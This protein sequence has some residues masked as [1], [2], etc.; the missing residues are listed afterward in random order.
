MVET[1]L[2]RSPDFH[3]CSRENELHRGWSTQ[4]D[5]GM[6]TGARRLQEAKS[7]LTVQP[8]SCLAQSKTHS[9]ARALGPW[10]WRTTAHGHQNTLNFWKRPDFRVAHHKA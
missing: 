2:R 4:A 1:S 5:C 7:G 6:R 8:H 9:L 3:L 10:P